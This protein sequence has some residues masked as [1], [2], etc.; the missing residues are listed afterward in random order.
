VT[1]SI[2]IGFEIEKGC[3]RPCSYSTAAVIFM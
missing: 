2:R 1:C 3:G